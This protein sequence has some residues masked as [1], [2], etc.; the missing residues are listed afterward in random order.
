MHFLYLF[1]CVQL[2][3]RVMAI[4]CLT[5][6]EFK[7]LFFYSQLYMYIGCI[8]IWRN[9]SFE[10]GLNVL[11]NWRDS[12]RD[13]LNTSWG[14]LLQNLLYILR[15]EHSVGVLEGQ[16]IGSGR[17]PTTLTFTLDYIFADEQLWRKLDFAWKRPIFSLLIP[18]LNLKKQE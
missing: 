18:F 6:G 2:L 5:F 7:Y 12:N 13:N 4:V 3:C 1:H 14:T 9:K 16:T 15:N 8:C 10:Q 17:S 11:V